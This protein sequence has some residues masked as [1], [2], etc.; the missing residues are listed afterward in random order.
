MNIFDD[1][2]RHAGDDSVFDNSSVVRPLT[3]PSRL[4]PT[5]VGEGTLAQNVFGAA[6]TA[7]YMQM[8]QTTY[9]RNN[10]MT[11][12]TWGVPTIA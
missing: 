3:Y 2:V 10:V 4:P 5:P 1:P 8:I 11:G 6:T 9:R 12:Y 7:G